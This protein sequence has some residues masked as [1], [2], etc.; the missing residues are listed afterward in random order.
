MN[1]ASLTARATHRMHQAFRPKTRQAY[2]SMFRIFL[3]FCI[4]NKVSMVNISVKVLAFLECLVY[5]QCS[6]CVIA[7]YVS[8]IRANFILFDLPFSILDHPKIKYF[9]K[10]VAFLECLVYNQ[11]SACVIA[12]YVSASRAN[13][14]LF[15]L[16]FSILDHP[17]IKY[18]VKS[19]FGGKIV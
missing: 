19:A 4:V 10:S 5:N 17:K 8:A 1:L 18:F 12:N 9:V 3:A 11:C 7:N 2:C 13:F 14:I 6:A 16:P 15:D